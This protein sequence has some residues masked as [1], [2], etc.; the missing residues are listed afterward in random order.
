[1][2]SGINTGFGKLKTI[3]RRMFLLSAAKVIIFSG[4]VTRLF[5]LQINENK[6]YLTLSDKN[7]LREWRL[8]PVRGKFFDFFGNI[9]AGNIEIYQLH[10]IPEEVED[11]NLNIISFCCV[12][13]SKVKGGKILLYFSFSNDIKLYNPEIKL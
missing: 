2:I 11:F 10:V 13:E 6:K 9:V 1:M 12:S 5:S 4:I 7:R 8:P 3:N